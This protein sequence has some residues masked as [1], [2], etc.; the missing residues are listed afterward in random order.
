MA[1]QAPV[2]VPPKVDDAPKDTERCLADLFK[3][4]VLSDMT[5][6]NPTSKATT[7]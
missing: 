3:N 7:R 2:D 4:E 6:M 5:L 1:D